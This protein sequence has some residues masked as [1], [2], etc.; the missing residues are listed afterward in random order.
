[1]CLCHAERLRGLADEGGP[2][3]MYRKL[4]EIQQ[5]KASI[6]RNKKNNPRFWN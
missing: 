4:K 3:A 5:R 6:L 1:M 2:I